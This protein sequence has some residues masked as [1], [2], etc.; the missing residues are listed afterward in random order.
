MNKMEKKLD[1]LVV[2]DKGD[3][4]ES[5]KILLGAQHNLRL[6]ENYADALKALKNGRPDVLLTDM[7]FP[8]GEGPTKDTYSEAP[9]GYALALYASRPHI[10]VPRIAM[11]TDCNHH[12]NAIS[13]TFD[14]FQI[15]QSEGCNPPER[16]VK[17][18]SEG[19]RPLF[20]IND[21]YFVMFDEGDLI[22]AFMTPEG[23]VGDWILDGKKRTD[24]LG[25][26]VPKGSKQVKNW[27]RA[28]DS[29]LKD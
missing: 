7:M 28:L 6:V 5:A 25:Y 1:I 21:S 2:E 24:G 16:R 13:A 22:P 8:L 18:E 14:D 20:K 10:A 15:Y 11:I 26:D 27:R 29:I 12:S 4:Q 3:H 17:D 9:L 19:S 23:V